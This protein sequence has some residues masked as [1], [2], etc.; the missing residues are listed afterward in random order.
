MGSSSPA[1][2]SVSGEIGDADWTTDALLALAYLIVVGSF[3]GFTA[4]VWLL[5]V[6]PISLVSTYAYVNPIVAVALG[7]L[8]L[9]EE[10][11]AQMA[12]AGGGRARLGG[13]DRAFRRHEPRARAWPVRT[14]APDR[15]AGGD[16]ADGL[17]QPP[18]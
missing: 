18:M 3:V 17:A 16:R 11:T 6:A 13:R 14:A 4:Y 12:V 15:A 2:R 1:I 5:R 9:D 8:I 10:I 7:W